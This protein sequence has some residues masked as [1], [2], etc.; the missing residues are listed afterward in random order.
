MKSKQR[1][2]RVG[3]R[4]SEHEAALVRSLAERLGVSASDV[5]RMAVRE[6]GLRMAHAVTLPTGKAP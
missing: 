1:H 2:E 3:I 4:L 6:F 5:V